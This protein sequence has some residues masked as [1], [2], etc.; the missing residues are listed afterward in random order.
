MDLQHELFVDDIDDAIGT[1]IMHLGGYKKVG[2]M[3]WPTLKIDSA[4]ARLKACLRDDKNEKLSQ[5]EFL[6]LLQWAKEAGCHTLMHYL[7]DASY[8][9][10]PAP[11]SHEQ[12]TND[13]QKKILEKLESIDQLKTQLLQLSKHSISIVK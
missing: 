5:H 3:L 11:R 6:K 12:A 9:E 1:V 7:A 8:Y 2:A 10:R 4:Y 13:L